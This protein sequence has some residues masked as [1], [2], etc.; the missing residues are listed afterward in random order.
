MSQCSEL[1]EKKSKSDW[2][3]I[4]PWKDTRKKEQIA[5]VL[6]QISMLSLFSLS[7]MFGC[8]PAK[9][10]GL[11]KIINCVALTRIRKDG[12]RVAGLVNAGMEHSDLKRLSCFMSE[13]R[14]MRD[15]QILEMS[16]IERSFF[17]L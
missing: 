8:I 6:C 1:M 4:T 10:L 7:N 5:S 12:R 3:F 9:T 11:K 2:L 14:F 13:Q 17:C 15:G 16:E